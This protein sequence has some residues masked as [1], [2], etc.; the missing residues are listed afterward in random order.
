MAVH[1]MPNMQID[2][3][4]VDLLILQYVDVVILVVARAH[5]MY[6]ISSVCWKYL[7]QLM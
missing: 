1:V 3:S 7:E 2:D 5:I 4:T 6:Y